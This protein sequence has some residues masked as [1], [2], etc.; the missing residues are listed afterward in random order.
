MI[1][2]SRASYTYAWQH[3][4]LEAPRDDSQSRDA[5]DRLHEVTIPVALG[6]KLAAS[7]MLELLQDLRDRANLHSTSATV[8]AVL[9]QL[10]NLVTGLFAGDRWSLG[11]W[12]RA[13]HHSA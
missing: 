6:W 1:N 12:C 2:V 8:N 11:S 4:P 9:C 7:I 5:A 13:S 10:C 3:G